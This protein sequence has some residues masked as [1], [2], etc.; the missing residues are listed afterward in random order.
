LTG[1]IRTHRAPII[2]RHV[3]YNNF[4]FFLKK[5]IVN[6]KLKLEN[7]IKS[8]TDRTTPKLARGDGSTISKFFRVVEPLDLANFGG[9][10]VV[11]LFS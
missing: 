11:E 1:T 5:K 6:I 3:P 7:K 8:M 10:G 4:F 2:I 9:R